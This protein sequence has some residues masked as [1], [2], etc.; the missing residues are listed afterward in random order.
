MS[1]MDLQSFQMLVDRR[2]REIDDMEYSSEKDQIPL[3]FSMDTSDS[4][5]ERR[6]SV[7]ELPTWDQFG[8]NVNYQRY[9][10][11]YNTVATHREFNQA[12]RWTRRM[13]DDDLTGIMRGDA[14]RKMVRSGI[15]TRQIHAARL[16]NYAASNDT[17]FY[18]RSEGVPL[19]SDSHT[20]RT[21]GVV[22]TTGFDNL[23]TAEL[24]PV[25]FR[26]ARQQ[27]RRFSNDQG[28]ITDLVGDMLI[29]PIELEQRAMEIQM[30]TGNPDNAN[31][32]INTERNTAKVVVPLY[33]TDTNNWALV[34]E[35]AMKD[36]C[37]WYDR[38]KREYRRIMDFETYQL[39]ASGYGRWSFGVGDWRWLL[40]GNV[41]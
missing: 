34:N 22:T 13:M 1:I 8:G 6:G 19:A 12:L 25:S 5:E 23:T 4:Y 10:E 3:F 17:F 32:V 24:S 2:Y 35:A 16:W 15:V 18:V 38:I 39:K 11:Q 14:Y 41:S 40:F 30:S 27:M 7:G 28:H 9:F 21:P 37:T 20:T 29:V 33:M 26:A 36:S 31:N